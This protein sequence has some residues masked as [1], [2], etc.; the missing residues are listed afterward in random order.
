MATE[1]RSSPFLT[2]MADETTDASN[3]EQV[4]LFV[5]WISNGLQV[6]ENFVGLQWNLRERDTLRPI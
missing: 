2:I 5:R 4:T 3:Q 6:Q 1:F